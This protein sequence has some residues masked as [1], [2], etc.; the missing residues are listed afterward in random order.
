MRTVTENGTAAKR[1]TDD[2]VDTNAH[3]KQREDK[4]D[5]KLASEMM[6]GKQAYK[7][8][9]TDTSEERDKR[10]ARLHSFGGS[11]QVEMRWDLNADSIRD[12]VFEI[13]VG[14]K[15]AIISAVELQKYIRWV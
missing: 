2:V 4:R 10:Y 11:T 7:R 12:Q 14:D 8:T 3:K 9:V 1:T 13:R 6:Y 5:E 15:T